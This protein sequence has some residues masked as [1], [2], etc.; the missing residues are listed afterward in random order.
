MGRRAAPVGVAVLGA[1]GSSMGKPGCR[2]GPRTPQSWRCF[3]CSVL[4]EREE[5]RAGLPRGGG[6][7][8]GGHVPPSSGCLS[9][10]GAQQHQPEQ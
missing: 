2:G 1:A 3:F 4:L 9:A 8:G 5:M 10:G 6:F 7:G